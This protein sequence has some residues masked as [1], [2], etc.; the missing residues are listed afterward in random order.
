MKTRI[1]LALVA[2]LA[3]A[4]PAVADWPA[5]AKDQFTTECVASA[6]TDHSRDQ[7]KAFCDCAADEVAKEFSQSELEEMGQQQ[8][9]DAATQQRLIN[10]STACEGRLEG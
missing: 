6:R 10:A 2:P 3:F 7:A 1:L 5:G 8:Q 4:L 9:V